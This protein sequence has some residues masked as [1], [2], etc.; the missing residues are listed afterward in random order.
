[1]EPS[2]SPKACMPDVRPGAFS[3]RSAPP[4]AWGAFDVAEAFGV[5]RFPCREFPRMR[6][7]SDSVAFRDGSRVTSSRMWPSPSP[8]RVGTPGE[9]ISELDGWPACAPVNASP[10]RLPAPAHD[11]GSRWFAIP[12]SCGSF[13]RYSLPALTGA[14]M[15]SPEFR[16]HLSS[17]STTLGRGFTVCGTKKG[18][19]RHYRH[20][21]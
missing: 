5:S 10:T 7:V 3:G 21:P 14:F 12:F 6:R 17:L 16:S 18:L 1:M 19:G 13:I 20:Y 2:D 4:S 9:V 11:S 15:V 8:Y